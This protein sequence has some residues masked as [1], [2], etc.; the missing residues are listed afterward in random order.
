[1]ISYENGTIIRD[2]FEAIFMFGFE[3]D[4]QSEGTKLKYFD[5]KKERTQYE[6]ENNL[7][8]IV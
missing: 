5:T 3:R 4:L 8:T 2:E 7:K 6:I 1:M